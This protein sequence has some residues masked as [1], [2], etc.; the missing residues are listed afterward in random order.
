MVCFK[1]AK[2]DLKGQN[3][4]ADIYYLQ[5]DHLSV[6]QERAKNCRE[7]PY[8]YSAEEDVLGRAHSC[9]SQSAMKGSS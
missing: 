1:G 5:D 9:S 6:N 2:E 3:G 7:H 4:G 8:L